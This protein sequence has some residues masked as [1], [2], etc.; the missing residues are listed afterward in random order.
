MALPTNKRLY[1]RSTLKRIVKAHSGKN[2]G[3]NVDVLIWLDYALFM[4]MLTREAS[5][6]A[7]QN[8]QRGISGKDVRRVTEDCLR[9]FKG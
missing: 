3:R 5:I 6:H 8:G 9:K 1:P 7:K 4:Q 2:V